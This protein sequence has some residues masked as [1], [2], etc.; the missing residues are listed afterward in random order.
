MLKELSLR[1]ML[2]QPSKQLSKLDLIIA[3]TILS[4]Y[5]FAIVQSM[6]ILI[7]K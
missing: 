1:E 5:I 4:I 2:N 7:C 6:F 3:Y